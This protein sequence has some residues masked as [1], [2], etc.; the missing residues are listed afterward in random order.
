MFINIKLYLGGKGMG[1][2]LYT[3]IEASEELNISTNK[4]MELIVN[5]KLNCIKLGSIKILKSDLLKYRAINNNDRF[6][7]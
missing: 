4:V 3:I 1:K 2:K 6:I 5:K 7:K